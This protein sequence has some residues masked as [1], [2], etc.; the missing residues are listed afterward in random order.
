[1]NL[2]ARVK[3]T[4][5]PFQVAVKIDTQNK[6]V[7]DIEREHNHSLC[8]LE[9]SNFKEL[10]SASIE[11]IKQLYEAGETPSTARQIFLRKFWSSCSN[12]L[13]YHVKKADW[14][15]VPKREGTFATFISSIAQRGLVERVV[16]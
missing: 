16:K 11:E 6:C 14:S 12:D 13:H 4:N 2:S 15:M 8:T 9:S 1:M 10:S 5:C 7:I 3:N